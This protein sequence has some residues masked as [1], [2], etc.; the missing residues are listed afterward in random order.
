MKVYD[1]EIYE[2]Q[3]SIK[4]TLLIIIVFLI[5]F[6][7]GYLANSFTTPKKESNNINAIYVNNI[8]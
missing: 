3:E 2:K 6:F 8:N 5:G 7:A 1:K 4:F